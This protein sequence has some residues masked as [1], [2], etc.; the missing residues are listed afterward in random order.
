MH[1]SLFTESGWLLYADKRS[2]GRQ[3]NTAADNPEL[4]LEDLSRQIAQLR[5]GEL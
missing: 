4:R 1:S 5:K 3:A 2:S